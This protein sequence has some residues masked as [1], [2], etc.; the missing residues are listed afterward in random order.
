[1]MRAAVGCLM[2]MWMLAKVGVDPTIVE[3]QRRHLRLPIDGASIAAMKGQFGEGRDKGS[4]GHE[5]VDL[6][7]PRNTPVRAVDDGRIARLFFSKAGGNTIY[8]FDPTGRFCYYYAHLEQYARGIRQGQPVKAG[9][10][11]GYVGTSGNAPP[12]TPHLHLAIFV[13]TK[14]GQW[15]TGRAIDPY[16]VYGG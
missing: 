12:D 2:A 13:V 15:W 6:I 14:P 3:L 1:M 11:I 8:Q 16:L 5:A 4:R 10:V 9:E 7:A